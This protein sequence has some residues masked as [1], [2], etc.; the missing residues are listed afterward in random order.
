MSERERAWCAT[1]D[2]WRTHES[3]YEG[4]LSTREEVEIVSCSRCGT[5][6]ERRKLAPVK[7]PEPSRQQTLDGGRLWTSTRKEGLDV[8]DDV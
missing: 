2:D 5:V 8:P 3:R 1:C 6:V 4:N 7:L